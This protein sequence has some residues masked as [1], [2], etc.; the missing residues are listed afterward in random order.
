MQLQRSERTC[1]GCRQR[2]DR[3][4]LVRFVLAGDPPTVVPDVRR[5]GGSRGASVHPRRS[6]VSAAVRSGAFRRAFRLELHESADQLSAWAAAQY[7]RRVEGLLVAA[8]RS[9][10]G[11]VG[12]DR[13][14]DAIEQ[15]RVKLLVVASDGAE[16][17]AH[18]MDAA[19]RLGGS[20]LVHGDKSQLGRLFGREQ[21]AVV[22]VTDAALARE[23]VESARRAAELAEAS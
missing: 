13:V 12:T 18:L 14:R 7:G 2:D 22:A 5:V 3:D 20:C 11:V 21:L 16:S 15:H 6:C 4:A 9:G 17:R 23:L 10:H 19:R 1:V 8:V